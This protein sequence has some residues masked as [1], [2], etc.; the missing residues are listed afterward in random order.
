VNSKRSVTDNHQKPTTK[1]Q[2]PTTNYQQPTTKK[3]NMSEKIVEKKLPDYL[4][5]P[6][7]LRSSQERA[8]ESD[9]QRRF[10]W[11]KP[12]RMWW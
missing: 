9:V 2:L 12:E 8:A 11:R 3:K 7:K 5:K 10:D 4:L 6:E 1:N